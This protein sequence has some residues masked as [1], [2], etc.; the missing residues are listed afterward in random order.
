MVL[1]V[2]C[3]LEELRSPCCCCCCY[4][5]AFVVLCGTTDVARGGGT[6]DNFDQRLGNIFKLIEMG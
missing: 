2:I 1:V 4:L 5:D 3:F 6:S